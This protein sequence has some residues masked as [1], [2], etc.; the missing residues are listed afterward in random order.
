MSFK[1]KRF[2]ISNKVIFAT[3]ILTHAEFVELVKS[4]KDLEDVFVVR[5]F[6]AETDE[7]KQKKETE[8]I[9]LLSA[10]RVFLV[11]TAPKVRYVNWLTISQK[12]HEKCIC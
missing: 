6:L 8:R 11:A 7:K 12:F 4:K 2:L 5:A 1:W 3:A 10:F 9:V